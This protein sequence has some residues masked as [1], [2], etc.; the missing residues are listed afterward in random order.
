MVSDYD[1]EF[2]YHSDETNKV[3]DALSQKAMAFAITV[4]E[5]P[6]Q[7]KNDM[8]NFEMEVIVGELLALT[9][10]PMIMEA[11]KG[12]QLIDPYIEKFK[13]EFLEKKQS[14]FFI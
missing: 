10:Q 5:M 1:C 6:K 14:N 13:Q 9:I 4:E 2:Y 3:A 12:G 7:L 11:I 8:H